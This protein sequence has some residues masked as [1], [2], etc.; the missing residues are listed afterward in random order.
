MRHRRAE[1][2]EDAVASRLNHVTVITAHR[3]DHQPE[4]GVD[5]GSRFFGIEILPEACRVDDVDEERGDELALTLRHDAMID[6][7]PHGDS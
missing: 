7:V 2:S 5:D 1:Q 4:R 6:R 3:V